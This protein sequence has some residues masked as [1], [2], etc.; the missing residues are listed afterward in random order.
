M[1]H[2]RRLR[3]NL[4]RV[5]ADHR[6]RL[7]VAYRRE[8]DALV[9]ALAI[10]GDGL[11]Q[12]EA[13]RVAMLRVRARESSSTWAEIVEQRRTGRGRRPNTRA[14]ERARRAAALDDQSATQALD[15]LRL[16]AGEKK[17]LDPLEAVRRAVEE[18]N[19][20]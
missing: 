16:L 7:A 2:K 3:R 14:V 1:S 17:P 18:A 4:E 5:F 11:L 8:Y 6:S 19:R 13:A 15:R 20:R 12:R 9:S 10:N